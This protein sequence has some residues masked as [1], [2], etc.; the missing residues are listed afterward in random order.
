MQA[1]PLLSAGRLVNFAP[2]RSVDVPLYW[3]Q[4]KLDSPTLAAVAG[5]VMGTAGEAL[6]G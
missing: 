4:W 1:A 2:E 6:R 5:A 3:Q